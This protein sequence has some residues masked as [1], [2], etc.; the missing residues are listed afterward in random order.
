MKQNFTILWIEDK[1]RVID[2]QIPRIKSFLDDEG[3]ELNLLK[4]TV[5]DEFKTLLENNK[6]IDIIVTDYNISEETKGTDVIKHVRDNGF[7]TD[8]LF[9]SVHDDLFEDEDIYSKLGHYGLI[10]IY[11]DKEVTDPLKELIKKNLKRCKDIVF[12]RGFV[13]SQSIELELKL[14]EF[15]STYFEVPKK[16]LTDFHNIILESRYIPMAGKKKWLSQ[17]LKKTD[18][19]EEFKGLLTNLDDISEKRNLLA[20]CKKDSDNPNILVSSGKDE[21][22]DRD[23]LNRIIKKIDVVSGHLDRLIEK[24]PIKTDSS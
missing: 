12:L 13:I 23:E 17:I 7:L 5:G 22:I 11:K 8:I 1:E 24:L 18:F 10:E 6:L 9:Y 19:M 15:F 3:F 14:N 20:H 4:D 16:Q 2:S 21:K